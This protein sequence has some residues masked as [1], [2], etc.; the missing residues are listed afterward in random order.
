MITPEQ[1]F[2]I[3]QP[4]EAKLLVTAGAGTGKTFT[5]IR[6]LEYLI[7][8]GG[9][10]PDQMGALFDDPA[11]CL[12]PNTWL[13]LTSCLLAAGVNLRRT[14]SCTTAPI[15]RSPVPMAKFPNTNPGPRFESG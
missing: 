2:I 15:M 11:V 10:D 4:L 14:N 6:R 5:L 3:D 7:G 9:L 12:M 13:H 1:Q 8:P